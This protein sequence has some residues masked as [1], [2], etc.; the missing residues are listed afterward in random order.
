MLVSCWVFADKGR[1]G[2]MRMCLR[3]WWSITFA[4]VE[5]L[6]D[7]YTQSHSFDGSFLSYNYMC[8]TCGRGSNGYVDVDVPKGCLMVSRGEEV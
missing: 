4:N 2:I 1:S 5:R 8:N 3:C 6:P 7:N